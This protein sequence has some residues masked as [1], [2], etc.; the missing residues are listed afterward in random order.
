[1]FPRKHTRS[2]GLYI[3]DTCNYYQE[4]AVAKSSRKKT[5]GSGTLLFDSI[6][7]VGVLSKPTRP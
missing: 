3:L 2:L 6:L 5:S 7:A 1:M 4:T